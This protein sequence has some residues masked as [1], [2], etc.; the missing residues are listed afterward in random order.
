MNRIRKGLLISLLFLVL[1]I[2]AALFTVQ[3]WLGTE[4]FRSRA[5]QEA[6]QVLGVGVDI[7]RIDVTVWPLPAVVLT[8]IEL[9]T[10][11]V[12]KVERLEV[13]PAWTELLLGRVAPGTL[14]VRRAVLPQ[15]AIDAL[16]VVL[17]KK[18][19]SAPPSPEMD[20]E[21]LARFLPRRTVL[22][23][24]TWVDAKGAGITV[25]ADARLGPDALPQSLQLQVLKG[26]LQ[27]TRLS[28][29]REGLAWDVALQVAGGSVK[30]RI[31][32][33]P[34]AQAGAEFALKGR[35]QTRDVEVSALTAPQATAQ[36]QAA[37]PLSGRLEGSTSLNL[38]AR[39]P[40]AMLEALQTQSTFTVHKAV[41][42]GI[43]LVKAVKS[44]GM[45]RG[46]DT[47]FD[48]MAGQVM[49]RGKVIELSHL[50]AS[51][52]ALSATGQVSVA[53]SREL[54]GRV[55]VELGGAVGVPLAVGGTV[56]EP[57]V[58]LTRGAQIG[59]ALGTVLMPGVGTGAGASV[60]GKVGEGLHKLFG[61]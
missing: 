24:V 43:D 52:G 30:G 12:L 20:A 25:Q 57:E 50:V 35:L 58:T 17:Q 4:E 47:P 45:S 6:R 15:S 60:G 7:G 9:K 53:A 54:S 11:S 33:Q 16:M 18:K 51:S 39:L 19:R 23:D 31:V 29:Q 49:T 38:H 2:A 28:L 34:A 55:S 10:R 22:D 44:V 37:Q 40:S 56:S 32:L 59:A 46:G 8:Q 26:R 41:L 36:A 21:A 61:N 27:G 1:L 14:I 3:R 13:R 42:H 48:T 5:M